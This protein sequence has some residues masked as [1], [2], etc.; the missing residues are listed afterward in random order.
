MRPTR[1]GIGVIAVLAFSLV[2][3]W[4]YGARSLSAIIFP[5][6]IVII[7]AFVT[8]YR[9]EAPAITRTPVDDGFVGE[10]RT[11]ETVIE[12]D[13]PLSATIDDTVQ[14]DVIAVEKAGNT[15]TTTIPAECRFR[16]DIRLDARGEHEIGPLSIVVTDLLGLMRRRFEDDRTTSVLVF[17]RVYDLTRGSSGEL[18]MLADVDGAESREEFDHLREYVRGDSLRDVHWKSAAKRPDGDLV[19][20]EF[21]TDEERGS[22]AVAAECTPGREDEMATAVASVVTYL[23]EMGVSVGVKLPDADRPPATGREHH[24][25]VLA[26]LAVVEA[27]ELDERTKTSADVLVQSD[28]NGSAV[29]VDG[30][31]IPFDRLRGNVTDTGDRPGNARH[32]TGDGEPPEV[33]P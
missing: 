26:L 4:Q 9:T 8:I 31:E 16:Y 14:A 11:I 13:K 2:M 19:V 25:A 10:T 30:R 32:P 24:R 7:A 20:K 21:V 27:G 12:P 22:T 29:V 6:G 1:R 18:Q 23:L 17:P 33:R 15:A 5:L 28:A 3:A